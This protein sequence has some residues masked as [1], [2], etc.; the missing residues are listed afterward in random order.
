MFMVIYH[1][2]FILLIEACYIGSMVGFEQQTLESEAT[3]H[4]LVSLCTFEITNF[5]CIF[6]MAHELC[7]PPGTSFS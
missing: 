4:A 7:N 3:C 6:L 1:N 2:V 5:V